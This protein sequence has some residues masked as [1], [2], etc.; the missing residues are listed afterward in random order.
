MN[1]KQFFS[2]L[3]SFSFSHSENCRIRQ[4]YRISS[5]FSFSKYWVW[6]KCICCNPCNTDLFCKNG[7]TKFASKLRFAKW[8]VALA[9]LFAE[10]NILE[11]ALWANKIDSSVYTF[12]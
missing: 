4:F 7:N 2:F 3:F 12:S 1:I 11:Q 5:S 6:T 10:A 9:K 8:S